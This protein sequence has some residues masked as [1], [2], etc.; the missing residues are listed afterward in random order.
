MVAKASLMD[1]EVTVIKSKRVTFCG[2]T[3]T[4][5][6]KASLSVAEATVMVAKGSLM[7]IEMTVIKSKRVTFCGRGNTYGCQSVTNVY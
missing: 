6:D 2:R 5:E 7:D 3:H 4:C 1:I